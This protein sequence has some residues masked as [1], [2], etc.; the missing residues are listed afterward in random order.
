MIISRTPFRISFFGGGTDYPAWIRSHGGSVLATT[1]DKYCHLVC[2]Y[3]PPFFDYRYR[4]VYSRIENVNSIDE[5]LHPAVREVLRFMKIEHGVEVHHDSDLP[6]RSGLGSSSSFTVGFLNALHGLKG[7]MPSKEQ[8]AQE[9]IHV[10]Q[11]LLKET[12]GSQDQILAAHG[13]FNHIIF[14]QNG[15]IT[16]RPVTVSAERLSELNNRLMMFYTGIRRT[17]SDIADSYA[18]KVDD[19]R[20]QLRI[21]NDLVKEGLSILSGHSELEGFG[22]LLHE[23]WLLKRSLSPKVSNS[24]IDN[25]YHSAREAGA[26]GGKIMGAGGGGFFLLYAEP[27]HQEKIREQFRDLVYVPFRFEFMGSQ[28][29]FIDRHLKTPEL[30][31]E[32][33]NENVTPFREL[34]ASDAQ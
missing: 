4:V 34:S 7:E 12:V 6:A 33:A 27:E 23:G 19:N 28:I 1:I 31:H 25:L 18:E 5:I 22:E 9:S 3:L 30:F 11:D 13:G 24:E 29:I 32:C 26:R 21:M 16:V 2:R 20:R 15:E 14:H 10:E 17:A 8:L